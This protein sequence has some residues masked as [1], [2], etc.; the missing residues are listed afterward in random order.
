M[1]GTNR[2]KGRVL[3]EETVQLPVTEIAAHTHGAQLNPTA[4]LG[5][6]TAQAEALSH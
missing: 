6:S 2:T 3:G 1:I 5:A 4:K